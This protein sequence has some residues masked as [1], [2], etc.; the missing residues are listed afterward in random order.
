MSYLE[1]LEW[2]NLYGYL[3]SVSE[4]SVKIADATVDREAT[5]SLFKELVG[6]SRDLRESIHDLERSEV[7]GI[8]AAMERLRG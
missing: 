5:W 4:H 6:R 7:G 1:R 8:N 3:Q 2:G